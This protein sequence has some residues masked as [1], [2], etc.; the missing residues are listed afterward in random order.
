MRLAVEETSDEQ[1]T[2]QVFEFLEQVIEEIEGATW[3][4]MRMP[5]RCGEHYWCI[6]MDR[7]ERLL[8]VVESVERTFWAIRKGFGQMPRRRDFG[9]AYLFRTLPLRALE[10]TL[11][12]W[13]AHI[14]QLRTACEELKGLV[15]RHDSPLTAS[16]ISVPDVHAQTSPS[17]VRHFSISESLN[18]SNLVPFAM[19]EHESGRVFEQDSEQESDRESGSGHDHVRDQDT[20]NH[21]NVEDG[22][23]VQ[24]FR[25]REIIPVELDTLPPSLMR[26]LSLHRPEAADIAREEEFSSRMSP[27]DLHLLRK[28]VPVIKL[29][30]TIFKKIRLRYLA[31]NK[32]EQKA[33]SESP[34]SLLRS[35]SLGASSDRVVMR[36][37]RRIVLDELLDAARPVMSLADETVAMLIAPPYNPLVLCDRLIA[38]VNATQQ[39]VDLVKSEVEDDHLRWFELCL[40]QLE[41]LLDPITETI[42]V[43]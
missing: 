12:R 28:C 13:D 16:A 25:H 18:D 9:T 27:D 38:L 29:V 30:H 2:L 26:N 42:P 20:R 39:L 21:D 6:Y 3:L 40:R 1:A 43:R 24:F 17:S 8:A 22:E 31:S 35:C 32:C 4:M 37:T 10:D 14:D 19:D 36:S 7:V 33:S 41:T 23:I 15:K 34:N 11:K 5:P